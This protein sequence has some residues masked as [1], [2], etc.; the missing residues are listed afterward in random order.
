LSPDHLVDRAAPRPTST[1]RVSHSSA[2]YLTVLLPALVVFGAEVIRHEWL[3]DVLPEKLGNIVTAVAALAI[4]TLVLFPVYR[5]LD[6]ADTRLR[7]MEIEHA[8]TEERD[9]IARDLH[10]GI[11]QALF[12]LNVKAGALAQSLRVPQA[13]GSSQHLIDEILLAIQQT[14]GRVRD[15]IFDLRTGPAPGEPFAGWARAYANRFA[16]THGL[17]LTVEE[18]GPPNDL[19][20]DRGL[21]A[22]AI[23]REALHNVAKHAAAQTAKI[24][25]EWRA[26]GATITVEDDGHGL[27][28]P[29]PGPAQGRYGLAALREHAQA[30]GGEV[31]VASAPGGGTSVLFLIPYDPG[32]RA[33]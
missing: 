26:G 9:R 16:E 7:V 19:P 22:M 1:L 13:P 8:V 31:R 10:D 17:G 15:A 32:G 5:R 18:I 33:A 29:V 24:R 21:H 2:R 11:S 6:D 14:A 28:D 4:S 30:A 25:I 3:H 12:F 27:P 23:V 20:L